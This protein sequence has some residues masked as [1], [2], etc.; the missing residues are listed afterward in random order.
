MKKSTRRG[1][2]STAG[3]PAVGLGAGATDIP[4]DVLRLG[5]PVSV[6]GEHGVLG[7][8]LC[9]ERLA[10]TRDQLEGEQRVHRGR[11]VRTPARE[12][13]STIRAL[14]EQPTR[15]GDAQAVDA[16]IGPDERL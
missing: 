15:D 13:L 12:Q 9:G 10:R 4:L 2:R 7:L 5:A 14:A 3:P 1:R 16:R 6:V 8:E 11:A